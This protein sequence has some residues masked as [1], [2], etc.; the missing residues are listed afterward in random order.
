MHTIT[1]KIEIASGAIR[2]NARKNFGINAANG[3]LSKQAAHDIW[4]EIHGTRQTTIAGAFLMEATESQAKRVINLAVKRTADDFDY[5]K[6][7]G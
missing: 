4:E 5:S 7:L 6:I 1:Q 2:Y 3:E